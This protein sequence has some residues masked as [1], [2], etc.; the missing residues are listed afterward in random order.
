MRIE[1]LHITGV[2]NL[3]PCDLELG[4]LNLF[5]GPNGSGKTSVLEAVHLLAHGRSFRSG[6]P[7]ALIAA[8]QSQAVVRAAGSGPDGGASDLAIARQRGGGTTLKING[9]PAQRIS[10][11]AR[12]LPV[13]TLLPGVSDL[14]F[15]SPSIRRAWLDWGLFHVKP[16]YFDTLRRFQRALAQRNA[17]LRAA[18]DPRAAQ[19][20]IEP[21]DEQFV[22]L[23]TSVTQ[24][25]ENYL[26]VVNR[27]IVPALS[28]V[29]PDLSISLTYRSG[30]KQ[31]E[32][33]KDSLVQ[34]RDQEVKSGVTRSGPHRGDLDI[35]CAEQPATSM[36]S[37]G[38][39]KVAA[40]LM[41][42]L[43]ARHVSE[44]SGRPT[45]LLVDDLSAELDTEFA[46]GVFDQLS[47]HKGQI[48]AT[49]TEAGRTGWAAGDHDRVFHVKHGVITPGIS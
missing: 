2:R 49:A 27:S 23:A 5:V 26:D 39:G 45:I 4:S 33:L 1:R 25:R 9:D 17:I 41:K 47:R 31:G 7:S 24:N 20:A 6:S 15:G 18:T 46:G 48:L 10:E 8:T 14:V 21:W 22:E 37:R 30:W 28:E 11:A 42:L 43:Q 40:C 12:L 3:V 32:S 36:L 38:Q 35:R 44:D 13:Q 34:G 16:E 29:V 19:A